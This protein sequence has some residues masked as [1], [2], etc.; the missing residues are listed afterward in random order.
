MK[1]NKKSFIFLIIRASVMLLV[2]LFFVIGGLATRNNVIMYFG[3]FWTA[4]YGALYTYIIINA[5]KKA[6]IATPV[7][8]SNLMDYTLAKIYEDVTD[9]GEVGCV[10]F[11]KS[12][13]KFSANGKFACVKDFNGKKGHHFAFYVNGTKLLSKPD[14]FDDVLDYESNLFSVE[15]GYFDGIGLSEP[16]NDNGIIIKDI[17]HLQGKKIEIKPNS[18][19]TTTLA[20]TE[21]DDIDCGEITFEQWDDNAR[22]ISFKLLA[23]SGVNDVIVGKVNLLEDNEE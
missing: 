23:L 22:I 19:Y 1:K 6:Q 7:P 3:I 15:L 18:G 11:I 8:T 20:T 4:V 21:W 5:V 2:G 17:A 16:E 9:F 13:L 14:D 12:K 10:S